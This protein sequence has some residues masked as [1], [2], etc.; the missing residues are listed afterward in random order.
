MLIQEITLRL[1]SRPSTLEMMK[2]YD[3]KITSYGDGIAVDFKDGKGLR[4]YETV[5]TEYK[6]LDSLVEHIVERAQMLL[7]RK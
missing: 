5:G 3:M 7:K 4:H 2:K 6:T 1:S